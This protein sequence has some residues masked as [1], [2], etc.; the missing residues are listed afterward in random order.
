MVRVVGARWEGKRRRAMRHGG[1][2]Q[3]GKGGLNA[4]YQRPME[5]AYR[6]EDI[7]WI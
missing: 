1:S 3:E 7:R 2:L 5:C 6:S 4:A